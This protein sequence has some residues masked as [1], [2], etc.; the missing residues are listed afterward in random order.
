L[1]SDWLCA[2]P[3]AARAGRVGRILFVAVALLGSAAANGCGMVGDSTQGFADAGTGALDATAGDDFAGDA[4][5]CHPG[6]VSGFTA[7][8][9]QPAASRGSGA[10]L[11]PI[12]GDLSEA[13]YDAC[14][15]DTRTADACA[16]FKASSASAQACAACV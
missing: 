6:D 4:A 5:S 2:P 14:L 11:D 10:C 7:D 8:T 15:G 16:A 13:F 1:S 3:R 9:Y 12:Q